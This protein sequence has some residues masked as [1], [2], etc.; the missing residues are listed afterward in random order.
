MVSPTA[1][2]S[3]GAFRNRHIIHDAAFG[4]DDAFRQIIRALCL[5]EDV[6]HC[7]FFLAPQF[8]QCIVHQLHAELCTGLNCRRDAEG[9]VFTNQIRNARRHD[10]NFVR[11]APTT[12]DPG[13]QRLGDH[14]DQRTRQLSPNLIL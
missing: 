6:F 8:E 13:Q 14:R 7:A 9:F 3:F 5:C 1:A 10:Q 12:A 4:V 2:H 11:R